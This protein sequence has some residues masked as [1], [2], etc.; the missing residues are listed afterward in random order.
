M[1]HVDAHKYMQV[2]TKHAQVHLDRITCIVLE[3]SPVDFDTPPQYMRVIRW[4]PV[5][6]ALVPCWHTKCKQFDEVVEVAQQVPETV[7]ND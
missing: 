2:C 5:A 4:W 6:T 1:H 7:T 3:E